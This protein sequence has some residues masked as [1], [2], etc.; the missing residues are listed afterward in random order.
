MDSFKNAKTK[1]TR[2]CKPAALRQLSEQVWGQQVARQ[3]AAGSCAASMLAC[4]CSSMHTCMRVADGPKAHCMAVPWSPAA[5]ATLCQ[6][7]CP[8]PRAARRGVPA[9][10]VGWV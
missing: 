4:S 10:P 8:P 9:T 5:S 6:A 7:G 2:C 3:Q 1:C